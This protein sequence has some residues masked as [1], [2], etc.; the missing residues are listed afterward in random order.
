M[1][2]QNERVGEIIDASICAAKGNAF[3]DRLQIVGVYKLVT[4]QEVTRRDG[5]PAP[6]IPSTKTKRVF[7]MSAVLQGGIEQQVDQPEFYKSL[8]ASARRLTPKVYRVMVP[9]TTEKHPPHS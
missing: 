2:Q 7:R 3:A 9:D 8:F 6:T 4:R 1:A 5:G